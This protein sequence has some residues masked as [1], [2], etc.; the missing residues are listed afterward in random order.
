MKSTR[1]SLHAVHPPGKGVSGKTALTAGTSNNIARDL[2]SSR[3]FG[4][5]DF[6]SRD[7]NG[8]GLRMV[9]STSNGG[10][11]NMINQSTRTHRRGMETIP[12][13]AFFPPHSSHSSPTSAPAPSYSPS[14]SSFHSLSAPHSPASTASGVSEGDKR[15]AYFKK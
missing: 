9:T 8:H 7:F 6:G 3:D 14:H 1:I 2:N 15:S 4:S 12:P 5:R 13:L 10:T 11:S